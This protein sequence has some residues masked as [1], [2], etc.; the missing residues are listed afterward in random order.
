MFTPKDKEVFAQIT[1][2][3]KEGDENATLFLRTKYSMKVFTQKE[4]DRINDL[5]NSL[6]LTTEQAIQQLRKEQDNAK[7]QSS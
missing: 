5:R 6:N 1:Q 2:L 4:I 3:A 7:D